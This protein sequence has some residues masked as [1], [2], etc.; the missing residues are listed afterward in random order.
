MC[1]TRKLSQ[2]NKRARVSMYAAGYGGV[3][4]GNGYVCASLV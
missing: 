2:T 4:R 1:L 3:R